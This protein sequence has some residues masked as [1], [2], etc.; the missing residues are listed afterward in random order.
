MPPLQTPLS[1]F[2][3][4]NAIFHFLLCKKKKSSLS[5]SV[6]ISFPNFFQFL[7]SKAET[8]SAHKV[9]KGGEKNT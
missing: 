1:F 2:F 8:P 3:A 4:C 9:S 6:A 5:D 7:L